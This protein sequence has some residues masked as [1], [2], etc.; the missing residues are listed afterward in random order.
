MRRR[1]PAFSGD[2]GRIRRGRHPSPPDAQSDAMKPES[3]TGLLQFFNAKRPPPPNKLATTQT[4]ST[5]SL[6]V[7]SVPAR[8]AAGVASR[9]SQGRKLDLFGGALY[10]S[11]SPVAGWSSLAA[12]RAHNPKVVGSNPTPATKYFL[13]N[14]STLRLGF[15]LCALPLANQT[16]TWQLEKILPPIRP[17]CKKGK[18][19]SIVWP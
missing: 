4:H 17:K 3:R 5:A 8:T 15:L 12:R 7:S 6:S 19:Q 13:K 9:S 10:N 14:P 16:R 2:D 11:S 18:G 1:P